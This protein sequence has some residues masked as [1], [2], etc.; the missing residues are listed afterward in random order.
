[1]TI[2]PLKRRAFLGGSALSAL[3]LAQAA[4]PR[5][6]AGQQTGTDETFTYEI[7]RTDAE[8][9]DMLSPP[10]YVILRKRSTELPKTN[11]LWNN[12]AK[13]IY[14]CRGCDLTVYDSIW[15]VE[16]DKG[17]AFYQQSRENAVLMGIDGAPPYGMTDGPGALIEA[18][19]RRCGSHL[20]HILSVEGDTLHCINGTSLRFLPAEV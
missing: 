7:T 3:A 9:R 5:A 15:K 14:C 12:T 11:P 8:W 19:C 2:S 4:A 10:E 17:W 1:M 6:A 20:G 13:G 18:R 16:L